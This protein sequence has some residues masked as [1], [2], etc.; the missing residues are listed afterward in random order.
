VIHLEFGGVVHEDDIRLGKFFELWGKEF[1][2]EQI[3]ESK[4]DDKHRMMMIVNGEENTEFENYL[5]QEEDKLE[6]RYQSE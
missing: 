2:S 5:L 3:F 4:V 1:N 6:I